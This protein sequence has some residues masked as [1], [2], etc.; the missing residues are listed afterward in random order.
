MKSIILMCF[1]CAFSL[2]QTYTL[3]DSTGTPLA[4]NSGLQLSLAGREYNA[5]PFTPSS[6]YSVGKIEIYT[7]RNSGD[8]NDRLYNAQIWT[9][10]NKVPTAIVGA[11]SDNVDGKTF[12]ENG[13]PN[14]IEF[15][16]STPV[17]VTSG[18]SLYIVIYGPSGSADNATWRLTSSGIGVDVDCWYDNDGIAPW[19]LAYDGGYAITRVYSYT[20]SSEDS[21]SRYKNYDNQHSRYDRY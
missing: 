13:S 16:F 17:A 18:D 14:W 9:K 1:L 4:N 20:V 12:P 15:T 21:E 2:A 7:Q 6:S 8:T 19:T 11:A 3:V 5:S 10:V